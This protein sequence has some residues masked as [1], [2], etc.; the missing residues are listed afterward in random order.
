MEKTVD[1]QT[2]FQMWTK[3]IISRALVYLEYI[4]VN[5]TTIGKIKKFRRTYGFNNKRQF[6]FIIDF[7]SWLDDG[8]GPK[9]AC[10]SII[11]SAR[12][13]GIDSIEAKV[14][15]SIYKSLREG[16]TVS[17]G[18]ED[19]FDQKVVQMFKIGQDADV[20]PQVVSSYLEDVEEMNKIKSE[21]ISALLKPLGFT[22]A[23]I[24]L[25]GAIGQL[26]MPLAIEMKPIFQYPPLFI[27]LYEVSTVIA[28][29]LPYSF[30]LIIG[31][32][33]GYRH[34][35]DNYIGPL[36]DKLNNYFP[37]SIFKALSAMS[38]LK[39]IAIMIKANQSLSQACG[40]LRRESTPFMQYHY[41][42]VIANCAKGDGSAAKLLDTGLLSPRLYERLANASNIQGENAKTNAIAI[43]GKRS[44]EEAVKSLQVTKYVAVSISWITTGILL[45]LLLLGMLGF[46]TSMSA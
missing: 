18:M 41:E 5:I 43:A 22:V 31:A 7:S 42:K 36:R 11:N 28:A 32:F 26:A 4:G 27:M 38:M 10:M 16:K 29:I 24:L 34:L 19:W 39:N 25:L 35:R 45:S 37:L 33:I 3:K 21:F 17:V 23:L 2:T 8:S 6:E 13:Q 12:S 9:D 30:I 14:A 46:M 15:A 40:Q 20:L 44:G 1:T